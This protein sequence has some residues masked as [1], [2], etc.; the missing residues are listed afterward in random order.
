MSQQLVA[1]LRENDLLPDRQSAYRAHHST[2]TA[3]LRVLSDILLALDSGDIA[4]LTLLD[5]AAAFDSVDHSTLLQR[6]QTSYGLGGPVLAWFTSYLSNRTQ[7]V[8]LPTTRSAESADLYGVPQGSV[9]GPILLLLYTTDL[10]QLIR[11]HH[12]HPHAYADDTQIYG[13]VIRLRLCSSNNCLYLGI[14]EVA[15]WMMSNRLQLDQS[16]Q[17]RSTLVHV[18]QAPASTSDWSGANRE[19][20]CDACHRAV[21]R[22][23]GGRR[24]RW[25]VL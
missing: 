5:L 11:R 20:I 24:R 8:R 13:L 7:Y 3:V 16:Y 17:D 2:E 9:R 18:F 4:V 10:L 22:R 23:T 12:L 21:R 1:Y 15:H 14:D 19:H 25:V 6:L